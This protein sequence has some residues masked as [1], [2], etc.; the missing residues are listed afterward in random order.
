MEMF[1]FTLLLIGISTSSVIEL[2]LNIEIKLLEFINKT[3]NIPM[4]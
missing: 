4:D 3:K 2:C 1:F